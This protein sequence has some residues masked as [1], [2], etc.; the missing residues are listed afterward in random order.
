VL[1][2]AGVSGQVALNLYAFFHE[3]VDFYL[4]EIQG[5]AY[6]VVKSVMAPGYYD[7]RRTVAR[8]QAV[9]AMRGSDD[10]LA[11]SAS[12]KR[13]KNI[14][15]QANYQPA[16]PLEDDRDISYANQPVTELNLWDKF[17]EINAQV[18]ELTRQ[19]NYLDALR[20][21]ATAR[22]EVDAFFEN[23]MVMDPDLSIRERR[24]LLLHTLL[25]RFS[26]IADF[27]E[28]VTAA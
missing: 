5:N 25:E 12:F 11:I 6:D 20:A 14:V 21:I 2:A 8:A 26:T 23:V 9:T 13:M 19:S 7:L 3:R 4:R 10:F 16:T 18:S 27:S 17:Y 15:S 24:L 1:G 22:P 28:I